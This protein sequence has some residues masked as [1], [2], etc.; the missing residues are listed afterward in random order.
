M[1]A[2]RYGAKVPDEDAALVLHSVKVNG[3]AALVSAFTDRLMVVDRDN[4]R[5][6]PIGDLARIDHRAGIRTGR[7]RVT[8]VQ[9]ETFEIRGIRAR[10][11]PLAYQVLVKLASDAR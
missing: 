3:R 1:T 6:I 9:G 11:T 5:R 10:D 4:T 8:T 7:I 2:E